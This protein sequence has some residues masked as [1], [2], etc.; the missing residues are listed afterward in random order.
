MHSH[1]RIA[2]VVGFTQFSKFARFWEMSAFDFLCGYNTYLEW[3]WVVFGVWVVF[4]RTNL[5]CTSSSRSHQL[6]DRD[7]DPRNTR[8]EGIPL[9]R[10]L[11]GDMK[12]RTVTDFSFY[13]P[14][15]ATNYWHFGLFEKQCLNVNGQKIVFLN[16]KART[17]TNGETEKH[18]DVWWCQES[19]IGH[20]VQSGGA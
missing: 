11:A 6:G 4:L 14:S 9:D 10:R 7:L 19:K 16:L 5:P 1:W 17:V 15:V 2:S 3:F 8:A 12:G 20:A 13:L 18:F